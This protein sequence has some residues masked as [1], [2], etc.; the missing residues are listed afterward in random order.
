MHL[1]LSAPRSAYG[2]SDAAK[3]VYLDITSRDLDTE[4]P[5]LTRTDGNLVLL[6]QRLGA[7][8]AADGCT[9]SL[10]EIPDVTGLNGEVVGDGGSPENDKLQINGVDATLPLNNGCPDA[11]LR[12]DALAAWCADRS[13][14]FPDPR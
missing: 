8:A 4:L 9:L 11:P 5:G 12:G 10:V 2:Y 14:P 7:A 6:V 3:A 1:I 13:I